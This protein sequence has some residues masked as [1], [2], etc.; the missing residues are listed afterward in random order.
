MNLAKIYSAQFDILNSFIVEVE[1][2]IHKSGIPSYKIVGL[3]D[4]AVEESK[5]RVPTAMKNTGFKETRKF[6]VTTSLS[7]A[8]RKKEGP[9]F[10]LPI[11]VGFLLA[12]G[13]VSF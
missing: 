5:E 1:I 9:L 2:D 8:D 6:K 7:P 3:G 12:N 10:D 13:E 4:K 11:A